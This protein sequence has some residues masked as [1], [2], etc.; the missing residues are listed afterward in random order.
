MQA[1]LPT[2]SM[3]MMQ[4]V[5]KGITTTLKMFLIGALVLL[6]MIPLTLIRGVLFERMGNRDSAEAEVA[7]GWG[8][9][10]TISPPFL[11]AQTS[12]E[13]TEEIDGKLRKRIEQSHLALL[14]DR[15]QGSAKIEV[16]NRTVGGIYQLP[17]YVAQ[18]RFS[19]EFAA[20]DLLKLQSQT[21]L[22][23]NSLQFE[24]L[25][26]DLRGIGEISKFKVNGIDVRAA[27]LGTAFGRQG[28]L[29]AVL[30]TAS[31]PNRGSDLLSSISLAD[32]AT[33]QT[34]AVPFELE[35]T[36]RGVQS[37]HALPLARSLSMQMDSAWP[38]PK[39]IG[40][41]LPI[42][43]EVS[44]T[45]FDATWKVS[46]FNRDFPQLTSRYQ[47]SESLNSS[48]IGVGLVQ[49]NDVYQRNDRAGKYGFLFLAM[50]IA[51][52]FLVEVLLKVRLHPMHYLQIGL[53]LG[54]FY[55]L[56][57]ALSERMGFN[58][59][60]LAAAIAITLLISAYT[61]SVL[62]AKKR[63]LLA[64]SVI[65]GTYGFLFMLIAGEQ[66]SLVMGAC[67]LLVILSLIM[68]L[69]R[70]INWYGGNDELAGRDGID[71]VK[72]A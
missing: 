41:L 9:R 54:L 3:P 47:D 15:V 7:D 34:R 44:P 49:V 43:R 2:Q 31:A 33:R 48:A 40:G 37:L 42:T 13:V 17:V 65:G 64:G 11:S 22:I 6:L 10:Q 70:H 38:H 51:G 8:A 57:L 23:P 20:E 55:L 21:G 56:L 45:G 18:I 28:A 12:R 60:F 39:F 5:P 53:A 61:A 25:A 29:G 58:N 16:T 59:A 32:Q 46:E 62:K 26:S 72:T 36:L 1:P 24:F 52:F 69:T 19:G 4:R 50:S 27:S 67:G 63:G 35:Y 66:Y 30:S 68:Y 71:D 14:A